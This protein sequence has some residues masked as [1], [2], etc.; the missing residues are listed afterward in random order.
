M[1][2]NET[3]LHY[4]LLA[5]HHFTRS[6][7]YSPL[8]TY[9]SLYSLLTTHFCY[10]PATIQPFL[11]LFFGG[12]STT[13]TNTH[14]HVGAVHRLTQGHTWILRIRLVTPGLN[15]MPFDHAR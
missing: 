9:Y 11:F 4:S 6:T 7:H 3:K 15:S 13:H 1:K 14:E 5:S 10:S 8:T 2:R 12:G